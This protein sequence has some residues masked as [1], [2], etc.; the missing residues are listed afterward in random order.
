MKNKETNKSKKQ[1]EERW[2]KREK[3]RGMNATTPLM[4]LYIST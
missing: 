4:I 3:E 2:R 1:E